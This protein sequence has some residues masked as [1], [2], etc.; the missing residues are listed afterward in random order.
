MWWPL[1]SQ[2]LAALCTYIL[3]IC[4]SAA[5]FLFKCQFFPWVPATSDFKAPFFLC[6]FKL[7][8]LY[9][10][11][12]FQPLVFTMTDF[13]LFFWHKIL[14]HCNLTMHLSFFIWSMQ[15]PGHLVMNVLV[16]SGAFG[17]GLEGCGSFWLLY[18][19]LEN[20]LFPTLNS[21]AL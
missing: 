12:T 16:F 6:L 15:F 21:E 5:I 8:R 13:F 19:S 4:N 9:S 14:R 17:M 11:T 2:L 18:R 20:V 1:K 10:S 3:P 7:F